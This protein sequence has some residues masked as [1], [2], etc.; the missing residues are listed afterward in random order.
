MAIT[1]KDYLLLE[2]TGNTY[3]LLKSLTHFHLV[4]VDAGLSE[5]T[6]NRLMRM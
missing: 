1:E 5:R 4:K 6:Y 3:M 2:K